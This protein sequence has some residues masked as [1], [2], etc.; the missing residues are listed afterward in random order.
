MLVSPFLQRSPLVSFPFN[1]RT[2]FCL[3]LYEP[4]EDSSLTK[5]GFIINE[6]RHTYVSSHIKTL[7]AI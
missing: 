2:A 1:P 5:C 4:L 6:C 3:L 7:A